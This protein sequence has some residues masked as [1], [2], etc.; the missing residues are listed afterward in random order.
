MIS[1]KVAGRIII[2]GL[3]CGFLWLGGCMANAFI[4]SNIHTVSKK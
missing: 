1:E 3:I 2:G 4:E